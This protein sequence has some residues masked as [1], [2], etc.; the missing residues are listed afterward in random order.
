MVTRSAQDIEVK[1][2]PISLQL[3]KFSIMVVSAEKSGYESFSADRSSLLL[4]E[5]SFVTGCREETN[6][7]LKHEFDSNLDV[8]LW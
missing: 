4:T 2:S 7:L 5:N 8:L 6:E 1:N 3:S